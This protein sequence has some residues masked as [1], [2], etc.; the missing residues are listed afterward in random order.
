MKKFKPEKEIRI[1]PQLTQ[2]IDK[3]SLL[4]LET[5]ERL[6]CR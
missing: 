4:Q 1:P 6:H 5:V 2:K 3:I